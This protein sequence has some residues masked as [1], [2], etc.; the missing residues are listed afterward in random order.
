M[1]T[2]V[3][4]TPKYEYIVFY[5]SLMGSYNNFIP[6]SNLSTC[7]NRLFYYYSACRLFRPVPTFVFDSI[8]QKK[9]YCIL[10]RAIF[11]GCPSIRFSWIRKVCYIYSFYIDLRKRIL[12]CLELCTILSCI[13]F[14]YRR[15]WL[16]LSSGIR[17]NQLLNSIPYLIFGKISKL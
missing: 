11:P 15:S 4:H 9:M 17:E 1:L 3:E 12:Y 2:L 14:N 10:F 7:F 13:S 8:W 16:Q 5:E 6:T